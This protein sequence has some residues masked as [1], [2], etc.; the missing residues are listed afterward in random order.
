[1]IIQYN[2]CHPKLEFI[3]M[4]FLDQLQ[5]L[6]ILFNTISSRECS[7]IS[8]ACIIELFVWL[9]CNFYSVAKIAFIVLTTLRVC[10]LFESHVFADG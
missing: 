6:Q 7:K 10:T 2:L 1:M 4:Q 9:C 5:P 8:H 3:S